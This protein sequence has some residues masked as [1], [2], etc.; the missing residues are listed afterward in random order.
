MSPAR[1]SLL[2]ALPRTLPVRLA[3]ALALALPA[4]P[5]AAEGW[6]GFYTPTERPVP[7]APPALPASAAASLPSGPA[8]AQAQAQRLAQG[9]G[10]DACLG[11]ILA[12]QTRYDI[13]GNLLLAVGLQEA[14]LRQGGKLTVWPWTVNAAGDGRMFETP[15]RAKAWVR[16]RQA[17]GVNSIDVGCMQVNLRW[18]PEAFVNLDQAFDPAANVDYAAR[19]LRDLYAKTGNWL[20][21]AGSYHSFNDEQ[22]NRYLASLTRNIEVANIRAPVFAG[23]LGAA[24]LTAAARAP[25]AGYPAAPAY[26]PAPATPPEPKLPQPGIGWWAALSDSADAPRVSIYSA[27]A[28]QPVLPNFKQE[29]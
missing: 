10:G 23:R 13:P 15:D 6:A 2:R 7:P 26:A 24:V 12:A 9:V 17:A 20:K 21:A 11:A 18:H 1:G 14:G 28:L 27:R 16:E 4:G 8:A 5:A 3:A 22:R 29:F 19:F 25:S